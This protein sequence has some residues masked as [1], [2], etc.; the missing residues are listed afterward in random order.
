MNKSLI[1]WSVTIFIL[2]VLAALV[3]HG[4]IP[5]SSLQLGTFDSPVV[6]SPT[7]TPL[8]PEETQGAL[9]HIAEREG[10]AT[11]QLVVAN[12]HRR[13]YELLG[14]AFWAITVL[15]IKNGQWYNVMVDL[16]DGSFVDDVEAIEQA[17]QEAHRVKYGKLEPALFERL[18]TVKDDD[19]VPVAIW[20]AG[21]PKR[22]QEE[23]YAALA[24]KYPEAQ[25]AL[26]RSGKPMDVG[27]YELINQ[28]ETEYVRMLE[29][30]TQERIQPLVRYLEGKGY[31]VTTLGAL[32]SIT[33]TLPKAEILE[34]VKRT[35][36]G[37]V[38]LNEG[39]VQR[40]LDSAVPSD[41]VP[42]VW[43]RSFKGGGVYIGILEPDK[44]DFDGPAV[45]HNYLHQ[46]AVKPCAGEVDWQK[47][48]VASAGSVGG[49]P[50]KRRFGP[51]TKKCGGGYNEF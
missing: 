2:L 46:G 36:V 11:D 28:I 47:T 6:P 18:E 35:D 24:A 5:V 25:A 29:A 45:G 41:R 32:P 14:R 7:P 27:D 26:E 15:D 12:Q 48:L 44:I 42:A 51:L 16:A 38:F 23:L 39:E 10:V 1:K 37:A 17:G 49:S 19:K 22:S 20:I 50:E 40:L 13:E 4:A 8:M 31:T 33:V 43:Q 9:K 21:E 30:D 34:L 3:R